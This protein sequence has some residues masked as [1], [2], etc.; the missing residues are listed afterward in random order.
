MLMV[1]NDVLVCVVDDCATYKKGGRRPPD[2]CPRLKR[3]RFST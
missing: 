2:R 3:Y 1:R